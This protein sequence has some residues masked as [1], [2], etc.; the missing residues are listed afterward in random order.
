MIISV[1][2]QWDGMGS[3]DGTKTGER[4]GKGGVV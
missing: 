2:L 3:G 1:W 4:I